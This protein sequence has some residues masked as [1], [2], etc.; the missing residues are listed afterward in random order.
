[1]ATVGDFTPLAAFRAG[2]E[3]VW[4]GESLRTQHLVVLLATAVLS[5]LGAVRFFRSAAG[6]A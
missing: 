5:W 3:D 1:V 6:A 4:V 2:L